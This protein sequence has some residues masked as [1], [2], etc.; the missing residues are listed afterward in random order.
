[1]AGIGQEGAAVGE[2][3]HTLRDEPHLHLR[4]HVLLHSVG[5][6]EEPPRRADLHPALYALLLE[7]AGEHAQRVRVARVEAVQDGLGQRALHFERAEQRGELRNEHLVAHA[8]EAGIRAYLFKHRLGVVARGADMVLL[9]PA[10]LCILLPQE[11]EYVALVPVE[12]L[13][14]ELFALKPLCKGGVRLFVCGGG[15]IDHFE[16]VVGQAAAH[17]IEESD[18]L[19]ER[20]AQFFKG[21]Y[22]PAD[23]CGKLLYPGG[24]RGKFGVERPVGAE[25]GIDFYFER[26]ILRHLLMP[27]KA[28]RGVV[29]GA[30]HLDVELFHHPAGGKRLQLFVG[31]LPDLIR[32]FRADYVVNAKVALHFKV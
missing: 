3:A 27:F 25:C 18:A 30:Y 20:A 31:V 16:R 4:L 21:R 13:F 28:V 15:V 11:G 17:F 19:F 1:M 24:K 6:I 9:H 14:R 23:G 8:V 29:G 5:L 2:H 12:L 32:I 7:A 10:E 26:L 22:L